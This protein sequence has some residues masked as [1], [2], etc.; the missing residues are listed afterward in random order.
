MKK[1]IMSVLSLC[2]L[3]A[4][5][6][7]S[8]EKNIDEVLIYATKNVYKV[9]STDV[10]AKI[11]LKNIENPQVYNS[12]SKYVIKDQLS[13]SFQAVLNNATG[14]SRLW[15]STGRA[16]DG[17]EYYTMRGF[18]VQPTL[19][20]GMP[21][22]NNFVEP[23]NIESTEVLKG[24]SGTLFGSSVISY[25]GLINVTTKKPYD[26]FG[27]EIGAIIGSNKLNRY[28]LD[29][30]APL[31]KNVF[32]RLVSAYHYEDSF[33][34][35]GFNKYIFVAPSLK[36]VASD[37]LT[38]L[39]NTE[40]KSSEGANAPMIFLSRYAPLS[41]NSIDIFEKYYKRSFTDN[42]LTVKTPSFSLQG[43]ALYK[44]NNNWTSQT[45]V[46]TSNSKTDGYYQ[47]L[48]DSAN[49]DEFTRFISKANGSTYTV[50]VQQNFQ[51]DFKISSIRNRMVVGLDYFSADV[52][53]NGAWVANGT[54]SL[55]NG[56]DTGKLT[57]YNTDLIL[58]NATSSKTTS[59]ITTKSLYISDVIDFL[60][61]LSVMASLRLDHYQGVAMYSTE[62]VKSQTTFSPK[63]GIV[64]QP[65]M[66][67]LS[68]F[69]NYMDGFKN[70]APGNVYDG[71]GNVIGVQVY[72]PER[73]NQWEVGTKANLYKDK[74]SLT[75]SY[76]NI[77]VSNKLMADA[78]NPNNQVQSGEVESKGFEIS[79][80][81]NPIQGLS[82]IAGYSYNDSKVT[83]DDASAGYLGLRPEEAG[84]QNLFN[85]WANY[86]ISSGSLKGLGLGV[87]ANYASENKTLNRSNIGTFT[88]PSYTVFNAVISYTTN[89][90]NVNLKFDNFTNEKYFTGWSTVTPQKPS[91]V[92]L[93]VD[94][95]F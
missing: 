12:I 17:A 22:V 45:V 64:Y 70:L 61:N 68:L 20:N 81:T 43:Q 46:S 15:E 95:K 19:V 36:V 84:P 16:G 29:V 66:N 38:F 55:V 59:S 48:W 87:G 8:K 56:T 76:Y 33:Q 69:A 9:D 26:H 28:T 24:P 57:P 92:A 50:D 44:I 21:N 7:E 14:V 27:G 25:G 65:I 86:K 71:S 52:E 74:I 91:T 42:S 58:S 23:I 32:A 1:T 83:K 11:P 85:F 93:G 5:S 63:F 51:G 72:D 82:M 18:S 80:V 62:E 31:G 6:Q 90:Y 53:S 73:A 75:A 94:F 10:V 89:K 41:F 3:M 77:L 34:D 88:L 54:V 60:P 49:G 79:L 40:F 37:K 4:Y 30:N 47:Y 2:S 67:K 35:A 78:T 13:T 39:I